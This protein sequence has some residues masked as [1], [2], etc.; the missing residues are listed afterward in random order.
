M[1][2]I[3][4]KFIRTLKELDIETARPMLAAMK[5]EKGFK[6][7]VGP[8]GN[9]VS[10]EEVILA[11]MHKLRVEHRKTFTAGEVEHSQLWLLAHG[12]KHTL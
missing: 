7:V 12:Y 8:F 3:N 5:R 6:Q 9:P 4:P 1:S 2:R 11:A 10:E